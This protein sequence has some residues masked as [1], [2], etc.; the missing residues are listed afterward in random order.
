MNRTATAVE[1]VYCVDLAKNTFQ[2][3]VFSP[4]GQ[5]LQRCTYTRAKFDQFFADPRC[6]PGVVVME[7]CASSTFWARRLQ[8][9]GFQTRLVPP[10]FVAKHRVGNKN[11]GNDCDAIFA[12]HNDPRVR[13]VPVKSLEQQDLCALHRW[14]ELLIR[15]R[16]QL[17]NQARG[18]LAERGMVGAKHRHGFDA[19]LE[20]VQQAGVTEDVTDRLLAL[21]GLIADQIRSLDA[22]LGLVDTTLE[23]ALASSPL[24]QLIDT[25][26][27][28][29]AITATAVVAEYGTSI[30]RFA[31]AR[32]FAAGIGITPR[33]NSSGQ[34]RRL[35]G[36]TKRGNAYLR[37]LLVQCAQSVLTAR[38]R[39]DDAI[40]Q[41]ARRLLERRPRNTVVVAIAN[42]LA[43]IIY[44]VMKHREPYHAIPRHLATTA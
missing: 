40:S 5:R 12:V 37:R 25:V 44:A 11:D 33:E 26:H 2:L 18:L 32:Q 34:R 41:L 24:A 38:L 22:Q 16:T 43:R 27:G 29:G 20:R 7:A 13:P 28:V 4:S 39:R 21:I 8:R 9:R 31:D 3:H 1:R 36:I 19:L 17:L 15:Q 10:Q 42:R 14:R 35:G 23:A 6:R 30:E